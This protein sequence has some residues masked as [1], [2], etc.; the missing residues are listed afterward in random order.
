MRTSS[1]IWLIFILLP[2]LVWASTYKHVKHKHWTNKY[3][4]HFKKN[5][6]HYFG[7]GIDW[8]WFKAQGIAESGLNPK[9]KSNVGAIGIMQ[10]MPATYKEILKKRPG[11]GNIEDPRWNIAAAIYYNRQLYK[12]WKKKDISVDERMNFTFASY[13]AGFNRVLKARKKLRDKSRNNNQN[14]KNNPQLEAVKKWD[15]VSPFTPPETRHYI[16]RI[17]KL[18]QVRADS[19]KS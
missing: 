8:H 5:S 15:K 7:P 16:R 9:A 10:I 14:D 11:L 4:R 17:D 6:K 18:M 12:R 3:D 19:G 13:N 2:A 1:Y